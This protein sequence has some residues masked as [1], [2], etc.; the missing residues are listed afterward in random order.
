MIQA[1]RK[2]FLNCIGALAIATRTAADEAIFEAY[3]IGLQDLPIERIESAAHDAIRTSRFFPS[4]AELRERSGVQSSDAAALKAW[5]ELN[6]A[7][8]RIGYANS[9]VF[10]DVALIRTVVSLGGWQR[11][12]DTPTEQFDTHTRREFL[13]T[14]KSYASDNP[15]GIDRKLVT[16]VPR[17]LG[18]FEQQ[19]RLNGFGHHATTK[20]LPRPN[21]PRSLE[22]K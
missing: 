12:C 15:Y 5:H 16:E 18:W 21:E 7:I 9:P 10:D 22:N 2:R 19:N 3:W 4:V 20:R 13:K 11:L 8:A 14:Y 6:E 17:L 1:D